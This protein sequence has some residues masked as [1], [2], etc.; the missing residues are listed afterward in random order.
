[1]T[2]TL[3]LVRHAATERT[4]NRWTGWRSDPPLTAEG[5]RAADDLAGR[6]AERL[7]GG[8]VVVSSPSL[9]A[10]ETARAIAARL[11]CAIA[12]DDDLREVDVGD[13]DGLTFDQASGVYP[14]LGQWLL[15]ADRE[16]DWPGGERAEDLRARVRAALRRVDLRPADL[17]VVLVSHG[18]V[19]GEL[20]AGARGADEQADRWLP[21]AAAV[22]LERDD[23]GWH[24]LDRIEP[25]RA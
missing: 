11:G 17:P 10:V 23:G 7:P 14:D 5:S 12:M 1:V 16:I 15:A 22:V 20:L 3:W 4:G 19:I 9:R 24:V 13:L 21:A 25:I 2:Q 6:L 8:A 18:G